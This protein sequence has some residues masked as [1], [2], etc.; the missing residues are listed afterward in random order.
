[1]QYLSPHGLAFQNCKLQQS[2]LFFFTFTDR[3]CM[4]RTVNDPSILVNK[5]NICI[6]I[7]VSSSEIAASFSILMCLSYTF[8][9]LSSLFFSVLL[10]ILL[11]SPPA[12]L[13]C[14]S[15]SPFPFQILFF[16]CLHTC[17]IKFR[18][19]SHSSQPSCFFS[20]VSL[21]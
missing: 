17:T 19:Q 18:E 8:S 6:H 3:I 15:L 20:S 14:P 4:M 11:T 7:A 2:F 16:F 5:K 12:L 13:F 1:M 10:Y 21:L 9:L